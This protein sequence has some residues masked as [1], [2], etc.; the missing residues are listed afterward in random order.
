MTRLV[1]VG[2]GI[3]GLAAAWFAAEAG[4]DVIVLEAAPQ[5]GGK[6][7]VEE[8]AGVP[9]DVGA[10]A[11][12]TVRPEGVDLLAALGLADERLTPLTTAARV[13]VAG[14][15]HPLPAATMLGI[16]S[17]VGPVRD[18]GVLSAAGLGAVAAEPDLPPLPPLTEDVA[19]GPLVRDRMGREVRDRLVEPLLG[20]VYA[21]R[22]DELSLCATMPG[23]AAQL[24]TGG[25]LTAAAAAA[26]TARPAPPGG[27]FTTL[28]G[29]LGRLPAALA[30][31][32]RFEIRTGVTV[33]DVRRTATGFVVECARG[34]ERSVLDADAVVVAAPAAKAARLLATSAPAAAADLAGIESASM[35]IVSFAFRDVTVPTGSGLLVAGGERL[36]T[37]AVTVTSQKWPVAAGGLTLLRASVGR[38]DE[39]AAL[40]LDDG[41]LAALVQR[42]LRPLLGIAA[43]PVDTRVTRWGGG[44]PQYAVGH[45]ERV[46]RI[47][48]AVA[49]VPGLAICGAA[50]DGVGVPACI[51]SA[52]AAVDRLAGAAMDRGQ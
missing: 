34:V 23:L 15:D 51:G 33:R 11:L 19:V 30:A 17:A 9:V 8:V 20:G 2:G 27:V 26:T 13:R 14:A 24:A 39:P 18:S 32:G 52:R 25:S 37:K 41:E 46:A 28:R 16:P 1:V 47:R 40:R 45:V 5:V 35:A 42:E 4:F 43:P 50:F 21:G 3:S 31:V 48:A 22:A 36:A 6:L 29:G 7:R 49:A 10:E 38:I 44:L 12:L